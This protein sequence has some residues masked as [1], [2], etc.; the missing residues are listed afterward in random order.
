VGTLLMLALALALVAGCGGEVESDYGRAR[1]QSVNGTA[2]L[3]RLLRARGHQVRT[4]IR[5]TPQLNEWADVIVRFA[6]Y[7]G[8]PE[9][10]EAT[11]YLEWLTTGE[12]R[13][14]IYVPRDY[15]AWTE[16]WDQ[17]LARLPQDQTE[18]REQAKKLRDK[19]RRNWPALADLRPKHVGR[20]EDWFAV[21]TSSG[22]PEVCKTLTG[23]WSRGIEAAQAALPRHETLKVESETVLLEGDDRPL[24][25]EWSRFNDSRV[26]VVANG[27]FLLNAAL[28]NPARRPLAARVVEWAGEGPR[29]VAFVE[30][31][32]VLHGPA[33]RSTIFELFRVPPFGWVAAQLLVLGLAACLARAPRLG[34]ARPEPP[35][36]EERPAAHPEALGALLARTGQAADARAILD[37]YRRWRNPSHP[38]R[39]GPPAHPEDSA[40]PLIFLDE[41]AKNE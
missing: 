4:A 13:Q 10:E 5:L 6:P 12:G 41:Q 36:G 21:D 17:A 31:R 39:G 20:P 26:L 40:E 35:S 27:S 2:V 34:R 28:L 29:R 32:F 1:D 37:A 23:P 18:R 25:I 15:D 30:G 24:A 7:P 14:M 38:A 11:W 3:A 33:D 9:A 8:P 16:Y 19:P 22:A